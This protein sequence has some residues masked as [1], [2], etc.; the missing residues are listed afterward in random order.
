MCVLGYMDG[1]K[2]KYQISILREQL[3]I[4][5]VIYPLNN[6]CFYQLKASLKLIIV[7]LIHQKVSHQEVME[8]RSLFNL[9]LDL[10]FY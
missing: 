6:Q 3:A 7:Y 5:N 9:Y 10:Y 1:L 8:Y 4:F 2:T